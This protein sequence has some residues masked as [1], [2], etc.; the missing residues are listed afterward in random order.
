MDDFE[1]RHY[2]TGFRVHPTIPHMLQTVK[3]VPARQQHFSTYRATKDVSEYPRSVKQNGGRSCYTT[4]H[5]NAVSLPLAIAMD[6]VMTPTTE[7]LS[8]LVKE[9][10]QLLQEPLDL[11]SRKLRAMTMFLT[12]SAADRY[13][14]ILAKPKQNDDSARRQFADGTYHCMTFRAGT[15]PYCALEPMEEELVERE[16][17][18]NNHD[19][20]ATDAFSRISRSLWR[21]QDVSM[22]GKKRLREEEEEFDLDARVL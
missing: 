11:F 14:G 13:T 12:E 10:R 17:H 22:A 4:D 5:G 7:M 15:Y 2:L 1:E 6:R 21:E 19:D 3:S 8:E 18:L 20:V 9:P 16:G